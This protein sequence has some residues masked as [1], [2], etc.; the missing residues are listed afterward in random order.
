MLLKLYGR[1]FL[2]QVTSCENFYITV[3]ACERPWFWNEFNYH[4][5]PDSLGAHIH[6]WPCQVNCIYIAQYLETW[7]ST[8]EA[9]LVHTIH[10]SR[11]KKTRTQ[12]ER[13]RENSNRQPE[14]RRLSEKRG[15]TRGRERERERHRAM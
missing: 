13:D 14:Q 6:I 12:R 4:M 2:Q 10:I 3:A 5:W 15:E 1:K 7:K 11:R 8:R 9:T